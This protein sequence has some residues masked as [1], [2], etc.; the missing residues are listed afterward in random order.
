MGHP[1]E[2]GF[3]QETEQGPWMER[4]EIEREMVARISFSSSSQT[5]SSFF[6]YHLNFVQFCKPRLLCYH[7]TLFLIYLTCFIF[8]ALKTILFHCEYRYTVKQ[9]DI[10]SCLSLINYFLFVLLYPDDHSCFSGS[11]ALAE[12]CV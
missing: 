11:L 6:S 2:A 5:P 10:M 1:E 7:M 4:L 3:M 9:C 12:G 8:F